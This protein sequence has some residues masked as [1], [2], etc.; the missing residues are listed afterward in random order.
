MP[1]SVSVAPGRA[2]SH[3]GTSR[4]SIATGDVA[5]QRPCAQRGEQD[6]ERRRQGDRR[7][8]ARHQFLEGVFRRHAED[9]L[10][11]TGGRAGDF[12][13][14][15]RAEI[16]AGAWP[17]GGE[18]PLKEAH[19]YWEYNDSANDLGV[20]VKL[21]GEDWLK[22]RITNPREKVIFSVAA[23]GPYK[24][25]G[26]TELFFEGAEPSLDDVPLEDLLKLFPEGEYEFEGVT[27]DGEE[28]EG[29][30]FFSHAIP[31]GPDVF[32]TVAGSDYLRIVDESGEDYLY[33]KSM[34]VGVELPTATQ[35]A[36]L[37]DA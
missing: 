30:A 25:L 18:I 23:K 22:L 3:G 13:R 27:V 35:K 24:D 28:T 33:P 37:A 8:I 15:R 1:A 31:D 20:H 11:E 19:I 17:D 7:R 16:D 5:Y 36:V 29:E 10:P 9:P 34:F 32:A 6:D 2:C 21:D 12:L 14:R 26:L 4:G